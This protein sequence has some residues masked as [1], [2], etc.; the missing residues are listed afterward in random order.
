MWVSLPL[1]HPPSPS[2]ALF[3]LIIGGEKVQPGPFSKPPQ[4]TSITPI[5]GT[6]RSVLNT[7]FS[8]LGYTLMPTTFVD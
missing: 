5:L 4:P 3:P 2:N 8:S 7:N 1:P 6:F